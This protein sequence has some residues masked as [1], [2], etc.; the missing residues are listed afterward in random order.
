MDERKGGLEH[1]VHYTRRLLLQ[2]DEKSVS[3]MTTV[4]QLLFGGDGDLFLL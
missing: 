4:L 2:L 1:G 3:I